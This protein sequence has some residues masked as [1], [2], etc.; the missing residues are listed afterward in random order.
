M[1]K[2]VFS[3]SEPIA[4]KLGDLWFNGTNLFVVKRKGPQLVWKKRA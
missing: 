2:N 3:K 1:N 4:N